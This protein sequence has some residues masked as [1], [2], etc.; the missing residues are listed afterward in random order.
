MM[1]QYGFVLHGG[2]SADRIPFPEALLQGQALSLLRL[3]GMLGDGIFAQMMGGQHAY[4]TAA[5]KSLPLRD[6]TTDR[7]R[8]VSGAGPGPGSGG[9]APG[10]LGRAAERALAERLLDCCNAWLKGACPHEAS[11][12]HKYLGFG[13]LPV[14]C[15]SHICIRI[16]AAQEVL[17]CNLQR[18]A[19]SA[20]ALLK[21][22]ARIARQHPALMPAFCSEAWW[23]S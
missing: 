22:I 18:Q 5:I 7:D 4:L 8:D 16:L 14:A 1:Q 17:Q 12:S 9:S 13:K 20:I 23:Y 10:M 11:T 19:R 3:E 6:G 21:Q 15:G 2:N